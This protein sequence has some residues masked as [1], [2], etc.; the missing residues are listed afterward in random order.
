[1]KGSRGKRYC[2]TV[3]CEGDVE[4]HRGDPNTQTLGVFADPLM[5]LQVKCHLST[6][7]DTLRWR[8]DAELLRTPTYKNPSILER[9]N[10]LR[11]VSVFVKDFVA[12]LT[13]HRRGP[14]NTSWRVT[15]FDR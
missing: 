14:R 11:R 2:S 12:V 4:G 10:S 7:S 15:E 13:K 5:A 9:L 8:G 1:M 6:S 3:D